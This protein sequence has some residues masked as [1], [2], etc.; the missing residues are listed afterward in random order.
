MPEE[1][2]TT[3]F[4]VDISDLKKNITEANR[5]VKQ[6]RAEL[7]NASAGMK[8]GEETADTLTKK[9]EAQSK[10]VAAEQAKLQA[11]KDELARYET[12]LQK[13]EKTVAELTKKHEDAAKALGEDS[14]EAKLLAKQ[15]KEAQEAQE[16]NAKAADDL[17]LKI[18]QQDTAVK[19]AEGKV[20]DF[21][22]ALGD[23]QE[24]EKKSAEAAQAQAKA[25]QALTN[26][27]KAQETELKKLKQEY[28]DTAAAQGKDSAEAKQLAAQISALSG[29]LKA[30]QTQLDNAEKSADSFDQSMEKAGKSVDDT[31]GKL[32]K[33]TSGGLKAFTV[34]LGNLASAAI[35]AAIKKLGE[36]A[37]AAADAFEQ[38][39][40]GRSNLIKSTG[41]TGAAADELTK[42]YADTAKSVT[43]DLGDIGSAIGEINTRFGFTGDALQNAAQDFI[44]FADVTGTDAVNAV[45]LVSRAMGDAGIDA[46]N[47]AEVLDQLAAASQASGISVDKLTEYLT[48]YGAPMRSL[49]FDTQESISIFSQW[50]KAG[51]NTET[52]FS[53]M[54]TAISNWSSEGKD[55]KKEFQ[56][57][58][59]EISKT[60]DIASATTKAIEVF[61]KK[62]GPDLADA[63]KGGRFE[64]SAFLDIVKNSSGTVQQTYEE[65]QSG[66]DKIKLAMQGLSV[67]VGEAAGKVVEEFAPKIENIIQ[68]FQGVLTGEDDAQETLA[69][70]V[71]EFIGG[72]IDKALQALPSFTGTIVRTIIMLTRSLASVAPDIV[73]GLAGVIKTVLLGLSGLLPDLMQTV[74]DALPDVMDALFDAVPDIVKA[75]TGLAESVAAK[76]PQIIKKLVEYIPA[77]VQGIADLLTEQTPILIQSVINI[78]NGLVQALP[79]IMQALVDTLPGLFKTLTDFMADNAPMLL[80]AVIQ[81]MQ[82]LVIAAPEI[83]RAIYPMIPQIADTL[84][85]ALFDY[86]PVWL[87]TMKTMFRMLAD[88]IPGLWESV[89][90]AADDIF[91]SWKT[92]IFDRARDAFSEILAPLAKWMADAWLGIEDA[93]VKI[94]E[95]IKGVWQEAVQNTENTIDKIVRFFTGMWGRIKKTF[96]NLGTKIGDA[97]GGAMKTALNTALEFI[98]DKL[99]TIPNII[100]G[101]IDTLNKLPGVDIQPMSTISLP[102]LAKG[103]V[104]DK[105]TLAQIG[106][107]GKE[108]V[109]P[110]EKNKAGLREI[111]KLLREEMANLQVN[112]P[113]TNITNAGKTT[114]IQFTQNNTSP[115]ALSLYDQWRQTQNALEFMKLQLQGG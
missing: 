48:K 59:E 52:A 77:L 30:N 7:A 105:A 99:N 17:R 86:F 23:L 27:V 12:T 90:S 24:A 44:K 104:I 113:T 65:A 76:L 9:I 42:V 46:E 13:G 100:N 6:Y 108:A 32:E 88:A 55:A 98:E 85:A 115:K 51:V 97:L 19:N 40:E 80:D 68:L 91:Q 28:T 101:A 103:A 36:M 33:T 11:L 37:K 22:E 25:D 16:R 114:N 10:I 4:K 2:V 102:R 1:N 61:G 43:G 64:Y 53:G 79:S 95:F 8:K 50:E 57:T 3:K 110:L 75:V 92:N 109:I 45:Q 83:A 106:E 112:A 70:A 56:K 82:A 96:T 31:D 15:L 41:A 39:D 29:E 111:A 67:T 71:A 54:K 38:F 78:F 18:V 66:I 87:D 34:A 5:Q 73:K 21:S 69:D 47:Y 63:I 58:L 49:G 93:F 84:V 35:T 62:A 72:V 81:L 14:E 107:N 60:P 26:V 89:K 94:G 74:T 20:R